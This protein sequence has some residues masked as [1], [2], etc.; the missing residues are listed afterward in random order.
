ML[1]NVARSGIRQA[2]PPPRSARGSHVRASRAR[3][4]SCR[5]PL[6]TRVSRDAEV[7][8]RLW[9]VPSACGDAR[10]AV[11]HFC[12]S[13]SLAYLAD[14]AELLTS[15]LVTNAI[16]HGTALITVL[17]IEREDTLVVAVG[18]DGE[19]GGL[20]TPPVSPPSVTAEGGRGIYLVDRIAGEWG[21]RLHHDGKTAWFRLP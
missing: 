7:L 21:T 8:L 2:D 20:I 19:I 9:P 14:D 5:A 10:H 4:R 12:E 3:P 11:R 18:D 1:N 13:R 6:G 16:K 17:A 15:E